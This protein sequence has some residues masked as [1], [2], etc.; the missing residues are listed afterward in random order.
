MNRL[1]DG[2]SAAPTVISAAH[3]AAPVCRNCGAPLTTPFCSE[4]GQKR[5]QRVGGRQIGEELWNKF[6]PLDADVLVA[7]G[8]LL[9]R[10]GTVA[11][12]YVFGA[13]KRYVN[14]VKLLLIG[15]AFLLLIVQRGNYL[16]SDNAPVSRVMGIVQ[17]W[18][19]LSFSLGVVALVLTTWL[20]YRGRGGFNVF[21][22]VVLACYSQFVLI[23]VS[24][25]SKLPTLVCSDAAFVASHRAASGGLIHVAS[26][27]VFVFACTQFFSLSLQRDWLRLLIA[28]VVFVGARWLL[29]RAYAFVLVRIALAST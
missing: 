2:D 9:R 26:A 5:A 7:A 17:T 1:I 11:R 24:I 27:L 6:K 22:H 12:E 25:V 28:T 18:A 13:R 14:P 29:V 19:N 23:V 15:A 3:F 20:F 10:P 8:L 4:C 16:A 21:E